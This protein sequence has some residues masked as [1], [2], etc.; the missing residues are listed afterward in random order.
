MLVKNN[1]VKNYFL[2][3]TS[4]SNTAVR[5]QVQKISTG[6]RN[7]D[8]THVLGYKVASKKSQ[9]DDV[10]IN[11]K[12]LLNQSDLTQLSREFRNQVYVEDKR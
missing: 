9:V 8:S 12:P 1:T 7:E 5:V 3:T 10:I 4:K 6:I 11:S 2:S